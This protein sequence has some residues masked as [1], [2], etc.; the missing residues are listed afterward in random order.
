MFEIYRS[1][2]FSII[3]CQYLYDRVFMPAGFFNKKYNKKFVENFKDD[4][5]EELAEVD[6]YTL[7][8]LQLK[9][10]LNSLY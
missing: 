7:F 4:K 6:L 2:N 8:L 10:K 1:A 5:I 3:G 9:L